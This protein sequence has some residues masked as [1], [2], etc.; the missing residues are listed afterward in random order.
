VGKVM[1]ELS[2]DIGNWLENEKDIISDKITNRNEIGANAARNLVRATTEAAVNPKFKAVYDR[3]SDA[4][5]ESN[6][7]IY[8]LEMLIRSA[9]QDLS[10]EQLDRI[11]KL[12]YEENKTEGIYTDAE[13]AKKGFSPREIESINQLRKAQSDVL[14]I[15]R[16]LRLKEWND[17]LSQLKTRYQASN[18]AETEK[19]PSKE[20]EAL[21]KEIADTKETIRK[22]EN[23]YQDLKDQGYL[24]LKRRGRYVVVAEDLSKPEGDPNR[25]QYDHAISEQAQRDI[26]KRFE[27]QGFKNIQLY[28]NKK[29]YSKFKEK[30]SPAELEILMDDAGVSPYSEEGQK[31]LAEAKKKFATKS[32][33]LP[34]KYTPGYEESMDNL[35]RG[36]VSQGEAYNNLYFRKVGKE[37]AM[38][39]LSDA[40]IERTDP[41]LYRYTR[42]YIDDSFSS[43]EQNWK[44]LHAAKKLTY[45]MQLGLDPMQFVFNGIFQPLMV[46]RPYFARPEFKLEGNEVNTY[47]KR[48]IETARE[49]IDGTADKEV[50]DIY[51]R[52]VR[53]GVATEVLSK[54]MA[55]IEAKET[56]SERLLGRG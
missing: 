4:E 14:D 5:R 30:L 36:L 29:F 48:G 8:D 40:N 33:E 2:G 39:A 56:G 52:T 9:K 13:L 24:T 54:E 12:R 45:L 19:G 42:D 18:W 3:V 10:P 1:K 44:K 37:Q 22:V 55:D 21:K 41:D 17:Y 11:A 46:T 51:R 16:D 47:F 23:Y 6:G 43:P 34:R 25:L 31:I 50:Q 26:K 32:Y 27:A 28:E 49:L 15:S 35:V 20:A 38:Q 53:E 7:R